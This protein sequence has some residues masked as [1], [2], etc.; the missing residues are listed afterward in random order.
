MPDTSKVKLDL[1]VLSNEQLAAKAQS[2]KP[3]MTGNVNFPTPDPALSAVGGLADQLL[4]EKA[5]AYAP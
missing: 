4:S 2:I 3:A 1:H 5:D